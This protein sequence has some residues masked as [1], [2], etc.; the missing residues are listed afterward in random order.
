MGVVCAVGGRGVVVEGWSISYGI[1]IHV[2]CCVASFKFFFDE[3]SSRSRWRRRST[4]GG[5]D[6]SGDRLE[7]DSIDEP[8][9]PWR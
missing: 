6:S 4:H 2:C 8:A 9:G 3:T 5:G 1:S 7:T